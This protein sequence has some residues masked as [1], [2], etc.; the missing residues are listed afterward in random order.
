MH[1]RT[2]TIHHVDVPGWN[3]PG[4]VRELRERLSTEVAVDNDVNLAAMAERSH[5]VAA[6][7]DGFALLWL[8]LPMLQGR[9]DAKPAEGK[10]VI[11]DHEP[12]DALVL[13]GRNLPGVKVVDPSQLNVYDVLDCRTLLVSQEAL[14][15]L[16]ERLTP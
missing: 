2:E 10:A 13:S 15:K 7:V 8:V 6:N 11:V 14:G 5:G 3:R 4:L 9:D 16:E 12:P 1:A